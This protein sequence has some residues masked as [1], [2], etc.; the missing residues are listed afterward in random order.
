[1][2]VIGT[3]NGHAYDTTDFNSV[4]YAN[5]FNQ[6]IGDVYD[7]TVGRFCVN[8]ITA[9]NIATG[10]K[11]FNLSSNLSSVATD[12]Q[13]G[14]WVYIRPTATVGAVKQ[15]MRNFMIG[16]VTASSPT[17][18]TINVTIARG[19]GNYAN[20]NLS[21]VGHV[22]STIPNPLPVANGGLGSTVLETGLNNI[23]AGLPNLRAGFFEDFCGYWARGSDPDNWFTEKWEVRTR[24]DP[25]TAYSATS[26][27]DSGG[28][29]Y[30]Q[31]AL[32][33]PGDTF[34]YNNVNPYE[35]GGGAQG[36]GQGNGGQGL[37]NVPWNP[38]LNYWSNHPG[39]FAMRVEASNSSVVL[40]PR[41][42]GSGAGVNSGNIVFPIDGN[43]YL[44]VMFMFPPGEGFDANTRGGFFIGIGLGQLTG[45]I[46]VVNVGNSYGIVS[47]MWG[48][49][50]DD[51]K[52]LMDL[53]PNQLSVVTMDLLNSGTEEVWLDNAGGTAALTIQEGRWYKACFYDDRVEIYS[54]GIILYKE[55]SGFAFSHQVTSNNG[56]FTVGIC[57]ESGNK[58]VTAI[59]DYAYYRRVITR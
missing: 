10:S 26:N 23:G 51:N 53:Y 41:D 31:A 56:I 6:L 48:N 38:G 45:N 59:V 37:L 12:L 2:S 44:E 1:M 19:T 34:E 17:Q 14:T 39:A 29:F 33:W 21:Y 42:P 43:D 47:R 46:Y 50:T 4:D 8:S 49:V 25:Y 20:W 5:K 16:V 54:D 36:T 13:P 52:A 18:L 35:S 27:S 11:V 32:I 55:I 58:A 57:K 40:T 30:P 3:I 24:F 22:T 9:T 28:V 15:Y 7:Y